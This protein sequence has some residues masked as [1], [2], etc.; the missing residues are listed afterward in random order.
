MSEGNGVS[1]AS[2][3]AKDTTSKVTNRLRGRVVLEAAADVELLGQDF[4][5]A[6][7]MR[8]DW[9]Q[10]AALGLFVYDCGSIHDDSYRRVAVPAP[11]CGTVTSP[12]RS[13]EPSAEC[14]SLICASGETPGID[15]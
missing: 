5:A 15:G 12:T 7:P 8:S 9:E 2:L 6:S 4:Q 10:F 13:H 3:A 14:A 11:L 1:I